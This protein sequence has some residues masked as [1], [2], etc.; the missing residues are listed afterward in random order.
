MNAYEGWLRALDEGGGEVR[1]GWADALPHEMQLQ[2]LWFSGQWGRDFVSE[3]GRSVRV[4]QFGH[5]NHG[6]GP[7][8]EQAVVEIDGERRSGA[9]ELDHRFSDWE[10]HGHA[11]SEAFNGVVLHVVFEREAKTRFTRTADHR[12]VPQ[13]VVPRDLLCETLDLFGDGWG[14]LARAHPGRCC[15]PLAR[16]G[17]DEVER[18]M[19]EAARYRAGR[20]ARWR[21][22]VVDALGEEEWLW[23]ALAGSLGYRPNF[24]AMTLLAQRLPAALLYGD[25]AKAEALLFGVSGFL[26]SA[27]ERGWDTTSRGYMRS[28]WDGW[29]RHRWEYE[30]T[31]ER[32]IPWRLA[33]VRPLNHPQR[34]LGAMAAAL[35]CWPLIRSMW[36]DREGL[37][38]LLLTLEHDY[39]SR[40]Y[41]LRSKA[42]PR[43][44]A[45]IGKQR[46]REFQINHLLPE[47]LARG[48]AEAWRW[49]MELAAGPVSEKV[50]R[51]SI[52]LLGEGSRRKKYLEKAWQHQ[53]LLQ[54]DQDFCR[55]DRSDCQ[56]CPFPEQ[57]GQWSG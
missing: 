4:V 23:Q 3:D 10:L 47:C 26:P 56:A 51:V 33:G 11:G 42:S 16:M 39:W 8:F 12:L 2:A 36:R 50:E 37:T 18:V 17:S 45:L 6:A 25:L 20:K 21:A 41:T 24:W 48:D 54:I 30:L 40:H 55:R 9:L 13:V 32:A 28:L 38:D 27:P 29:W 52:R 14:H 57:L 46:I 53:A 44:M 1:E 7:D 5:W 15:R 35:S 31:P 22:R 49:Y 34:R 43:A 19:F